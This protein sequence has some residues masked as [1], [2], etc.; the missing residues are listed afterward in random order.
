[1]KQTFKKF[2]RN[3]CGNTGIMFALAAVPMFLVAGASIDLARAN[4]SQAML[5]AAADAAA[6]AAAANMEQGKAGKNFNAA[7][8]TLIHDYIIAN[9]ASEALDMMD[10]VDADFDNKTGKLSVKVRG[11][12]KTSLMS[13]AGINQ[14]DIIASSE[15]EV[16]E[17]ALEVVLVLDNTGSMAGTKIAALKLA[18]S[19]LT[20]SVFANVGPMSSVKIGVVPF[21]EY[22]NVNDADKSGGWLDN[23]VVPT[24]A[25]WE[26]CVGSRPSPENV[27]IQG[28]NGTSRYARVGGV[29]CVTPLLPLT[30]EKTDVLSKINSM[31]SEGNTY[32]PGGLLWGWHVLN[33]DKPIEG[34]LTASE[35]TKINATKALV[36]MTDGANTISPT[37]P[38]HAGTDVA[39]TNQLTA[40]LCQNAK[41]ANIQVFTVA[42]EVTDLI[43]KDILQACASDPT[44]A[45]D[46]T[47]SEALGAAFGDI[48][49][50]LS[51]IHLSK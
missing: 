42:F 22:V 8:S 11:K 15:V 48:A 33:A 45:F 16:K 21:S 12:I 5:Q 35:M 25:A 2:L 47:N 3:S 34:G 26:G 46:A 38:M 17:K 1:M 40:Q 4:R 18:A 37:Y 14:M 20:E 32:I 51:S 31:G 29:A 27:S 23:D 44:M 30:T 9:N 50:Q 19:E 39:L 13:L 36:L 24:G 43:I 28:G 49:Q 6:L 7:V 10:G 41:A